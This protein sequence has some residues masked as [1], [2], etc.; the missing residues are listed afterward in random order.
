[1]FFPF[2]LKMVLHLFSMRLCEYRMPVFQNYLHKIRLRSLIVQKF[3]TQWD[4]KVS[5]QFPSMVHWSLMFR[6]LHLELFAGLFY[7]NGKR[8][9]NHQPHKNMA[10]ASRTTARGHQ[11]KRN[12]FRLRWRPSSQKW[13]NISAFHFVDMFR[14]HYMFIICRNKSANN[15][16]WCFQN[17]LENICPQNELTNHILLLNIYQLPR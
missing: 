5:K 13:W 8:I 2:S 11:R 12:K 17:M 6:H 14:F 4:I 9:S 1:M 7:C 10:K 3:T 16:L 15:V